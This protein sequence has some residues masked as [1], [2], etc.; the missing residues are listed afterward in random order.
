MITFTLA[1]N[2]YEL[3]N[4]YGGLTQW[5]LSPNFELVM[6]KRLVQVKFTF[7]ENSFRSV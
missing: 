6:A 3:G 5:N 4:F 7:T 1:L 2:P